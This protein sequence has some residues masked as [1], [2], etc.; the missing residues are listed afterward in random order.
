[1]ILD[2]FYLSKDDTTWQVQLRPSDSREWQLVKQLCQV[3]LSE[4]T[5]VYLILTNTVT[6]VTDNPTLRELNHTPE[7]DRNQ[8]WLFSSLEASVVKE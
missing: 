1:M 2:W 7:A 5:Q 8:Q 6:G 3:D 4:G